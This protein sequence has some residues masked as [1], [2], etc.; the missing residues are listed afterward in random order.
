NEVGKDGMPGGPTY[1]AALAKYTEILSVGQL[2]TANDD[3]EVV[4]ILDQ[5]L[6]WVQRHR[7][8]ATFTQYKA[9]LESF[10]P[11]AGTL[12][13][14]DLTPAVVDRWC[15]EMESVRFSDKRWGKGKKRRLQWSRE[16]RRN[17]I[18][19]LKTALNWAVKQGL[20]TKNPVA[21]MEK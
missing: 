12:R 18:K 11:H 10:V 6:Q 14:R 20:I 3:N 21:H 17:G 4:V 19:I 7:K 2:D 9:F 15:A 8:P 13:V 1:R 5:Y 16:G